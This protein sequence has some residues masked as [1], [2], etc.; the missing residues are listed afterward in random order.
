MLIKTEKLN[1]LNYKNTNT[2]CNGHSIK[3]ARKIGLCFQRSS[4]LLWEMCSIIQCF[5]RQVPSKEI[6]QHLAKHDENQSSEISKDQLNNSVKG[7]LSLPEKYDGSNA[8]SISESQ[9]SRFNHLK[10]DENISCF[11]FCWARVY[12][13]RAYF[14]VYFVGTKRDSKKF[15]FKTKLFQPDSDK[16]IHLTGPVTLID[17]NTFTAVE[18]GPRVFSMTFNQI[19]SYW[20]IKTISVSWQTSV[21]K[22]D[23][24]T[25]QKLVVKQKP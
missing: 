1:F 16:E 2:Y 18:E 4:L 19:K 8:H 15:H 10:L 21:F 3:S 5:T 20:N 23:S 13:Q 11:M 6:L 17:T 25:V 7:F 9:F 24:T 12:T 14:W 22:N